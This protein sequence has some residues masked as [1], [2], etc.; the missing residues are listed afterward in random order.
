MTVFCVF[1][2]ALDVTTIASKNY[3]TVEVKQQI[4]DDITQSMY[5]KHNICINTK[6]LTFVLLLL[7]II[8]LFA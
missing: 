7:Q 6:L 8:Y 1:S 4:K 3:P 5:K 2:V